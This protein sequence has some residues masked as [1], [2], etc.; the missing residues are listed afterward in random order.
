MALQLE[1]G[2][3]KTPLKVECLESGGQNKS[4]ST[5][6]GPSLADLSS[7]TAGVKAGSHTSTFPS[8]GD[9]IENKSSSN[10][11]SFS[12][13]PNISVCKENYFCFSRFFLVGLLGSPAINNTQSE[14]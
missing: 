10:F 6:K 1:Q 13:S 12:F 14:H 9:G 5:K 4:P 11:P 8:M 3:T 2:L 7:E